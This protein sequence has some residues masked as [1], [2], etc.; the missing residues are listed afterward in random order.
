M[1]NI[2]ESASAERII[3]IKSELE[4][5]QVL[6]S[7]TIGTAI[8][9]INSN[10]NAIAEFQGG[11]QGVPGTEGVPGC[12]TFLYGNEGGSLVDNLP[13][14]I[15]NREATYTVCGGEKIYPETT[16]AIY[17]KNANAISVFSNLSESDSTLIFSDYIDNNFTTLATSNTNHKIEIFNSDLNGLGNHILLANSKMIVDNNSMLCNSGFSISTDYNN[18]TESS[19][20]LETLRIEGLKPNIDGI[21]ISNEIDSKIDIITDSIKLNSSSDNQSIEII[22]PINNGNEKIEFSIENLK[23]SENVVIPSR[24]GYMGVWQQFG[25]TNSEGFNTFTNIIP[26]KYFMNKEGFL[27]DETFPYS[28]TNNSWIQFKQL[29]NF[30]LIQFKIFL[31]NLTPNNE[32]YNIQGIQFTTTEPTI[33]C[34]TPMFT[35][36]CNIPDFDENE[37]YIESNMA[38]FKIGAGVDKFIIKIASNISDSTCFTGQVWAEMS[39]DLCEVVELV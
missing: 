9:K 20:V 32:S 34:S 5:D 1:A 28:I 35:P 37:Y 22:T 25:E 38:H 10:F 30:V 17:N 2:L 29:N 23:Q 8:E 11:R 18:A 6:D 21:T 14:E 12:N 26:I 4:I 33:N 19:N 15:A 27:C 3:K 13:V 36:C 39:N 31:E 7:D 16:E 24:T